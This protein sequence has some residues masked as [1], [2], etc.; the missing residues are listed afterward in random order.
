MR[1]A[2]RLLLASVLFASWIGYLV[3]L[4]ATASHPIVLSRPQFLVA[5]LVVIARVEDPASKTAV[6]EEVIAPPTKGK[7]PAVGAT[8]GVENLDLCNRL[9]DGAAKESAP[10]GWTRPGLYILPL[11]AAKN[12]EGF[13]VAPVPP[14]PGFPRDDAAPPRIYPKTDQTLAQLKRIEPPAD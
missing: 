6:V 1:P 10:P 11:R 9:V 8:I 12:G 5:D 13:E 2:W 14:S 3:Y 4:W 7:A